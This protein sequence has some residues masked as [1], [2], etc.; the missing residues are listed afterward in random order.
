LAQ[1]RRRALGYSTILTVGDLNI[2]HDQ[3]CWLETKAEVPWEPGVRNNGMVVPSEISEI[4]IHRD[5]T[6]KTGRGPTP[7]PEEMSLLKFLYS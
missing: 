1:G 5:S 7:N 4:G 2:E 3:V 6:Q